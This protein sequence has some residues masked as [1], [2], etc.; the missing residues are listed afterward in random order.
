LLCT[1]T[2]AA[3][4]PAT[5]QRQ[6]GAKYSSLAQINTTNVKDLAL[7]WEYRTGEVEASEKSLDAFEDEPLLIEGNLIVCTPSRRLIALDPRSGKERWV[8]DPKAKAAGAK[9]CRGVSAW[10]D[11]QAPA[12]AACK[13][14][15]FLGTIDYRLFAVDAKTGAPCQGFGVGGVVQMTASKPQSYPG[16]VAATSRPAVINGIVVVGSVV[17]DNMRVDAP[18][19]RVLAFDA[20][21]GKPAWEFDAVPRS[22]TDPAA[23]TWL[24]GVGN[25][26]GGGNVWSQMAVDES[27]DLIYL[28]TTSASVDFFGGARPGANAYTDSIVALK[29]ATGE[30]AWHFQFVHHDIWDYDVPS[31]PLLIDWPRDGAIVPALVQNT[32]QGLIFVFNR[33]TGEPLIPIEERPVPQEG[34]VPGEWLSPTQPFPVGMTP[35]MSTKVDPEDAWGFTPVDRW[36]CKR[37]IEA[38]NHGPIYTP[39]SFKGTTLQPSAAGGSNWGGGAYDPNSHLMVVPTNRVPMILTLSPREAGE[40]PK[41]TTIDAT[42]PLYFVNKGAP[43]VGK[44]EPLLSPLGA[45]CTAPPWGAL[46]AVDMMTGE[47]RWEV[48]LGSIEKLAPVPIPWELGTPG[49]GG[50]LITAGGLVFIGFAMDD[51]LRAIDLATGKTIWKTALPAGGMAIPVTY[52]A[53]GEQY[54]VITAGGHFMYRSGK[55]DSVVAYKLKR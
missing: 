35:L 1:F 51:K 5:D 32:K 55:G 22:P 37:K 6:L 10:V 34:A 9:K 4:E 46:T 17:T 19:G 41:N 33:K 13:A 24:K 43:Y 42:K 3:G 52:E 28:P 30:V 11:A 14:R 49:A 26:I 27:L 31:Q 15:L 23:A 20:R 2:A 45:P 21:T 36:L 53:N 16:E 29:G 50:P 25:E 40:L 48:P 38:V 18:S 8:F 7:A 12:D 54:V 44:F 39:P 47:K